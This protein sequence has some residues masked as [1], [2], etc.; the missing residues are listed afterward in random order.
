MTIASAPDASAVQS[1][2]TRY[3][4]SL[5]TT[6]WKKQ[7]SYD[8]T[9]YIEQGHSHFSLQCLWTPCKYTV[10]YPVYMNER[11]VHMLRIGRVSIQ[12]LFVCSGVT[13]TV[14][15]HHH[16]CQV[17]YTEPSIYNLYI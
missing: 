11:D 9:E 3:S 15:G 13:D 8:D 6:S 2:K 5:N 17:H 10:R 14:L 4:A 12:E 1:V 16:Y 7:H